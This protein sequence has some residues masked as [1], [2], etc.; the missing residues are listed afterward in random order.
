MKSVRTALS[1]ILIFVILFTALSFDANSAYADASATE[2]VKVGLNY[3]GSAANMITLASET[4][5][6]IGVF[7][8]N[9]YKM[10][11]DSNE[12][13]AF[14]IR[15]D[16]YYN[17][18]NGKED[19]INY[20][21]AAKYEGEVI[22]PFHIQIG[23]TYADI[24]SARQIADKVSSI[25]PS[26]FLAYEGGWRVWSQLYLEESECFN[27][28][29]IMQNEMQSLN[30][31]VVYPDN[32]RIQILDGNTGQLLYILNSDNKIKAAPRGIQGNISTIQYKGK[33]YR[34]S[35]TLQSLEGSDLTVINELPLQQ[36]LYSVIPSEMPSTWPLEALKA[37]AVAAR[38]YTL[39]TMGRHS[40]YGFDLCASEHCQAY[41]GVNA[42]NDRSNEAVD[43]TSGKLLVY[44]GNLAS[45]FYHSSSGG[46]TENIENIWSG[47]L[48]YIK[49]VEDKF[50]LGSPHDNWILELDRVAI[51]EKLK[52]ADIDIGDILDVRPLEISKFGRVTKVEVKGTKESR[53]FE[54]EKLRYILGTRSLKSIWYKLK[55]DADICVRSSIAGAGLMTKASGMTVLSAAGKVKASS[56]SNKIYVK[57]MSNTKSYS[58]VPNLYTFEGK[59]FGHGL[60][61][62][63]YGAKG[64]ADAGYNYIKILEYYYQGAKV[65]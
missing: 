18:V 47:S 57:S 1:Y 25:T 10:L 44:D 54:R 23:D 55:T 28:I 24:N 50:S 49:G 2:T 35:I 40:D 3:G 59:G 33:K 12:P 58:I 51:R 31:S 38:N 22:G 45:A 52:E 16:V 26:V 15:K 37:Q 32:R 63:Q 61:M 34:G 53:I 9:G 6:E 4:G 39:L 62:S 29:Q 8:S 43:A 42:E 41:N 13:S 60:G 17:L 19:E 65:Q 46:Y 36:Y 48:A 30:Y 11:L 21:R 7:E 5:M 64:M 14:K 27:Q 20:V 56:P